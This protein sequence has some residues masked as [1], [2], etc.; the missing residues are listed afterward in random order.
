MKTIKI[1]PDWGWSKRYPIEY[2]EKYYYPYILKA[3]KGDLKA[4]K[5]LTK[6]KNPGRSEKPMNLSKTKKK[7]LSFL[8]KNLPRYLGYQGEKLFRK[9]FQYRAPV[10]SIFWSHIL[11]HTP[12][13][14]KYTYASFKYFKDGKKINQSEA[15]ITA[16]NHWKLLDSYKEWFIVELSRLKA[17][18][19][20]IN[21]R[22]LDRALFM[23]GKYLLSKKN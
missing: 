18:D 9:D 12:I 8:I 15:K 6:W 10:W 16:P 23:F 3:R 14:D 11:F 13:L 4:I 7:A 1:T 2:D 20:N 17:I 21:E 22:I 5:E 19:P